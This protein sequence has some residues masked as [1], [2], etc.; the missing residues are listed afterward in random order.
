MKS[1]ILETFL[2][3]NSEEGENFVY[4]DPDV[5]G[6]KFMINTYL[7]DVG[8][9]AISKST[10][11]A[12]KAYEKWRGAS[13]YIANTLFNEAYVQGLNIAHGTTATVAEVTNLYKNLKWK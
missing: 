13:N 8:P 11:Y 6:L 12:K 3:E 1:T 4:V 10:E 5:R 2:K 9:Y 7:E